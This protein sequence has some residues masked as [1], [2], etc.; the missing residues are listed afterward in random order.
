M[1]IL[2]NAESCPFDRRNGIGRQ[3]ATGNWSSASTH[4]SDTEDKLVK[5]LPLLQM[6]GG[7]WEDFLNVKV[8]EEEIME[9]QKHGKRVDRSG[10]QVLLKAWKMY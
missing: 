7:E 4:M 1:G 10:V 2:S 8:R 3:F 5:T 9:M 6:T